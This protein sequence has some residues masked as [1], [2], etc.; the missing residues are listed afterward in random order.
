V[1]GIVRS[2]S[3]SPGEQVSAG[4]VLFT[5][6][7]N[8]VGQTFRPT[9][10]SARIDGVVSEVLVQLEEQV[11]AGD[12][13][14]VLVGRDGYEL[15]AR[16]SDKDAGGLRTG[17]AVTARTAD[18]TT[19]TGRLAVRAAEPDYETG[20]FGVTFRFPAAEEVG[21]GTFLLVDLPTDRI[22]G[23]FVPR[24]AVDRRYGRYFVWAID[25]AEGVLVRREVSLGEVIGDEVRVAE[26]LGAGERYLERPTG[27][28][29]DGAPAPPAPDGS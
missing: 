16:V 29:R 8:E 24:D 6:E 3:V 4:T 27:R 2:V 12:A 21:I 28:E 23:I 20:L 14:A 10:V 11:G 17:Q 26:G 1:S 13:A 9:P 19:I 18:G 22:E 25:E 5:V 15:E 7:R